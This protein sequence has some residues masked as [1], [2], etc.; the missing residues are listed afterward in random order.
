MLLGGMMVGKL[1]IPPLVG[2]F[3][4]LANFA[5][6]AKLVLRYFAD[7]LRYPRGTRIMMGN[8]LVG[9]LYYSLRKR[10]VPIL[11]GAAIVDMLRSDGGRVAGA[12]LRAAARTSRSRRAGASCSRPAASR[13]TR[14]F[15]PPSCRKPCPP[16]R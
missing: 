2:R 7:R 1:D 3:R 12:R 4:S 9:R 14:S 8:A 13:A 5:Y 10:G 11:F 6:A 15:A 16:T